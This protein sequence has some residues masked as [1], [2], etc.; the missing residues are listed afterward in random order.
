MTRPFI[1]LSILMLAF[2]SSAFASQAVVTAGL[3]VICPGAVLLN[4]NASYMKYVNMSLSYTLYSTTNCKV[5][6]IN[7]TLSIIYK[8]NGTI[9]FSKNIT[10]YNMSQI[11]QS[12]TISMKTSNMPNTT[13]YAK[14]SFEE[15]NYA[16]SNR[17]S[18]FD[19]LNPA[20]I[21]I[22]NLKAS[23]SAALRGSPIVLSMNLSNVGQLTSGKIKTAIKILGPQSSEI[24]YNASPLSHGQSESITLPLLNYT[25][26]GTYNVYAVA[27]YNTTSS[28]AVLQSI[29]NNATTSFSIYSTTPS[30]SPAPTPTPLPKQVTKPIS[31]TP[32]LGITTAPLVTSGM[33]GSMQLSQ[34]GLDNTANSTE[35]VNISVPKQYASMLSF[36]A[37]SVSIKPN[38]SI[39]VQLAFYPNSTAQPGTYTIPVSL[40][41]SIGNKTT[42]VTEYTL[43]TVYSKSSSEIT[44]Q[45]LLANNTNTANG[46]V[47][48]SNPGNSTMLNVHVETMVPLLVA[49]NISDIIAYGLENNIT[50]SKGYYII[51]W[52]I[53]YIKAGQSTYAY[54]TVAKPQNQVL[55][56]NIQNIMEVPAPVKPSSIL[57]IIDINLPTFYSNSTNA[58]SVEELYTGTAMQQVTVQLLTPPG[59]TVNPEFVV[60]NAT[61]NQALVQ[62]FFIT[63]QQGFTGTEMFNLYINTKGFNATYSLPVVVLQQPATTSTTTIQ[64]QPKPSPAVPYATVAITFLIIFILLSILLLFKIGRKPRYSAERMLELKQMRE[65]IKRSED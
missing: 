8:N 26:I 51:N 44:D 33:Q 57:K 13:Y 15:P 47:K 58:I 17:S 18:V 1:I 40:A 54:Y 21:T 52:Y 14:I 64:Q 23:P 4:A 59:I 55:L 6:S 11:S 38:T 34:L 56:A 25:K 49:K 41:A 60:V 10:A 35:I 7:G 20:N 28:K 32:S 2:A 3:S 24:I 53:P 12:N 16:I 36:S 62:K 19:I 22:T 31:T 50:I 48:I 9:A 61:P 30:P 43:F 65:A 63:M 37:N 29:S 45:V 42:T 5:P 46:V 27:S 39:S